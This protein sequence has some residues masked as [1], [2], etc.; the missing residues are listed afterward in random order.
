MEIFFIISFSVFIVL[1]FVFKFMI[2]LELNFV[3]DMK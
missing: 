3:Y 1:D 2:Y